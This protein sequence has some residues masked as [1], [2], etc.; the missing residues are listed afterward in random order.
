MKNLHPSIHVHI[1]TKLMKKH[2]N[3]YADVSW[4]I[5]A[6]QL[7][8]NYNDT[9][10]A[11]Y[12]HNTV[13]EDFPKYVVGSIAVNITELEMLH[14]SLLDTFNVHEELVTTHGSVTGDYSV[15]CS[16]YNSSYQ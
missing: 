15:L 9:Q 3:L 5:L 13:H 6:K 10:H 4:D 1:I 14:T 8:M 2:K 11:S 16:N 12:L 7:F